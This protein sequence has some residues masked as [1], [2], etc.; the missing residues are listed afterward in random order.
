MRTEKCDQAVSVCGN[1]CQRGRSGPSVV[2][3]GMY[4][5]E[6]PTERTPAAT[7]SAEENSAWMAGVH[8]RAA[9]QG[10]PVD[11]LVRRTGSRRH[12]PL[13]SRRFKGQVDAKD[14][15]DA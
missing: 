12:G 6:E 3:L 14:G 11:S 1:V 4:R 10:S 9:P 8:P 7:A 5:S 13:S 15:R 2:T